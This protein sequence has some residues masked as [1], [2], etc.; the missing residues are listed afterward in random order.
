[1]FPPDEKTFRI[2]V[3]PVQEVS[4]KYHVIRKKAN[5]VNFFRV[6]FAARYGTGCGGCRKVLRSLGRSCVFARRASG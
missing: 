5:G 4:G 1:M 3:F 6:P 2:R